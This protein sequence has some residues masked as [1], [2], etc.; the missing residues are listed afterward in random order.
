MKNIKGKFSFII[1]DKKNMS[2]ERQKFHEEEE[3]R[4][5]KGITR[6]MHIAPISES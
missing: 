6:Y 4:R 5:N 3:E 2:E 1:S